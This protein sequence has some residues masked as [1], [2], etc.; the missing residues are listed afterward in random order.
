MTIQE[1]IKKSKTTIDGLIDFA[2]KEH[3]GQDVISGLYR[4]KKPY[5]K[6]SKIFN[7]TEYLADTIL[8][9]NGKEVRPTEED[10]DK[11]IQY[12]KAKG[13]FICDITVRD[14]IRM[15]K[16][17]EI[18]ITKIPEIVE[19]ENTMT[20]LESLDQEQRAL[21]KTLAEVEQL[22]DEVSKKDPK[23]K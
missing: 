1:Y 17:G 15:Y 2:K 20:R 8:L 19:E 7:K 9:I 10:V 11:C 13:S 12:L 5:Q 4:Y 22:E 23:A 21:Q 16:R 14:T 6:Y 18:D 3:L